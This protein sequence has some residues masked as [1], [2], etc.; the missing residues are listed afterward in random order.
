[1]LGLI[2]SFIAGSVFGVVIMCCCITAGREDREMEKL[3]E[4]QTDIS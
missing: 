1:M 2:L 3:R 4:H